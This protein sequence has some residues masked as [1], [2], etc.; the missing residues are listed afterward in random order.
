[1]AEENIFKLL[2][3]K[4]EALKKLVTTFVVC[5][6]LRVEMLKIAGTDITNLFVIPKELSVILVQHLTECMREIRNAKLKDNKEEHAGILNSLDQRIRA[7]DKYADTP[8]EKKTMLELI[9]YISAIE[10]YILRLIY[11]DK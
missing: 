4:S 10:D 3:Y 6:K 5:E 9:V 1:M 2:E 8:Q 11:S 7:I